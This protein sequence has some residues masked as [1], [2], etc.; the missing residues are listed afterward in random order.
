MWGTLHACTRKI[1][2]LSGR[3]LLRS[4][5]MRPGNKGPLRH[6][7]EVWIIMI[8]VTVGLRTLARTY[9]LSQHLIPTLET[10]TYTNK[11]GAYE[12]FGAYL[13]G[14]NGDYTYIRLRISSLK[15]K[16][17]LANY[18][19]NLTLKKNLSIK[20]FKA[21]LMPLAKQINCID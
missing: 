19:Q 21:S 11:H 15:I 14:A 12:L 6:T 7:T 18:L 5:F 20:I 2:P 3:G 16:R 8:Q 4:R 13:R 1:P 9:Y 10:F 17:G